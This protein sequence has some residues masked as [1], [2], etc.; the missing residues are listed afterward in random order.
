MISIFAR[1]QIL[2]SKVRRYLDLSSQIQSAQLVHQ[3]L[4]SFVRRLFYEDKMQGLRKY[5]C[6]LESTKVLPYSCTCTSYS[7]TYT[8]AQS[9]CEYNNTFV[10]VYNTRVTRARTCTCTVG[11]FLFR[12]SLYSE[13]YV[14]NVLHSASSLVFCSY[15]D[16]FDGP[17]RG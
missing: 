7:T 12:L 9:I 11:V 8:H 5:E 14:Q 3:Y 4:R 10:R 15:R 6:T 1:R 16:I 17:T 2:P 13:Q